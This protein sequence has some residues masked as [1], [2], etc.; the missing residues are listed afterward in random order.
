MRRLNIKL[1]LWDEIGKTVKWL[2]SCWKMD[3]E[4]ALLQ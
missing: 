1:V 2:L 4:Q 3:L